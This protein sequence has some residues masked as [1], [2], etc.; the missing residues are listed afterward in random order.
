MN[1][2]EFIKSLNEIVLGL[3]DE[4][5]I[6]VWYLNGVPDSPTDEDFDFIAN[7]KESFDDVVNCFVRLSKHIKDGIYI[8]N[9]FYKGA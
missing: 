4:D 6:D 5:L 9:K 8:D 7:D 3:G 1:K 2:V